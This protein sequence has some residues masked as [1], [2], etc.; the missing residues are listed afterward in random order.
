MK[1]DHLKAEFLGICINDI[2]DRIIL[3]WRGLSYIVGCLAAF[4]VSTHQILVE[5]TG[6]SS[7]VSPDFDRG[8]L[9]A[10]LSP[11]ENHMP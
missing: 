5:P 7:K 10:K 4:L 6:C 2:L 1:S 3:C 9:G 8:L 11:V